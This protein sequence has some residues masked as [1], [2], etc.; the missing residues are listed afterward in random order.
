MTKAET[1]L[2][3]NADQ[4]H[5][6]RHLVEKH[7]E[8]YLY[9]NREKQNLLLLDIKNVLHILENSEEYKKE[10]EEY[11]E[12]L[13]VVFG[14]EP[15]DRQAQLDKEEGFDNIDW[16]EQEDGSIEYV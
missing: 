1:K 13:N 7:R 12:R 9:I 8:D 10:K 2:Y 3:L 6:L 15:G 4:L 5:F 16:V 14:K 11:N